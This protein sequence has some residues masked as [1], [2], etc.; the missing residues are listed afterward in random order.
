MKPGSADA[1]LFDLGGVVACG[2]QAVHVTS[3][4]DD[5]MVLAAMA[6]R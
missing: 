1:L 3:D 5:A 4:T 2:L 6:L